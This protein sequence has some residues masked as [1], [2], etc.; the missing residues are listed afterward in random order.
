MYMYILVIII[1]LY[2]VKFG[3]KKSE[4]G[5]S[6]EKAASTFAVGFSRLSVCFGH[7]YIIL[8]LC[9]VKVFIA[10]LPTPLHGCEGNLV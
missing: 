1:I 6:Q 8:S 2:Y 9:R 3:L 4:Q 7:I 10:S 5:K